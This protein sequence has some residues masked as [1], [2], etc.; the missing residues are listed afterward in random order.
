M[1]ATVYLFGRLAKGYTQYLDDYTRAIF[2][3]FETLSTAQ[4]QVLTH[5][6]G[7]LIYYAYIRR[8][9]A[10]DQYIGFCF[11]LNDVMLTQVESLFPVFEEAFASMVSAG[12]IVGFSEEGDYVARVSQLVERESEVARVSAL[13]RSALADVFAS[14]KQLPPPRLDISGD[15]SRVFDL[16]DH[17]ADMA[18]A[19]AAIPY[20]CVFKDKYCD[21][22]T[23]T[24]Y[25]GVVIKLKNEKKR[26]EAR[27]EELQKKDGKLNGKKGSAGIILLSSLIIFFVVF[28]YGVRHI[29]NLNYKVEEQAK[30]RKELL[31]KF[32]DEQPLIVRSVSYNFHSQLLHC[33]Y[34][35]FCELT[36][37]LL[38]RAINSYTGKVCEVA[39]SVEIKK[40]LQSFEVDFSHNPLSYG[41][42]HYFEV[43]SQNGEKI[44]GGG[45]YG[46]S[47]VDYCAVDSCVM[48]PCEMDSLCNED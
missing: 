46:E 32:H 10:R 4:S 43:C 11:V 25:K 47:C 20:V 42:N 8:L 33:D 12:E 9:T 34:R 22:V 5:R 23:L 13:L 38:V 35:A 15:E 16:N 1:N 37:T 7:H 41:Y 19:T 28:S 44:F 48:L 40:E 2:S 3:K 21:T 14:S 31:R 27:C 17:A 6:E 36:D 29:I 39:V 45:F 24:S 26:L 30:Q 18:E